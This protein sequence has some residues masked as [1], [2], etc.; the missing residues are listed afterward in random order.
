M[1]MQNFGV[2]VPAA[3]AAVAAVAAGLLAAGSWV[4]TCQSRA[5]SGAVKNFPDDDKKEHCF[6][7]CY[8]NRCLLLSG[9]GP[10]I[11]GGLWH[12]IAGGWQGRDSVDDLIADLRGLAYSYKVWISCKTACNS[13]SVK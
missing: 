6:A 13:C 11:S 4:V 5:M 3:V 8:F 2:A 10:T 9:P 12:E 1:V 7:S